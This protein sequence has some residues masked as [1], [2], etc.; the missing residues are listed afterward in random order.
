MRICALRLGGLILGE[1]TTGTAK[2]AAANWPDEED[3]QRICNKKIDYCRL[4]PTHRQI[5][6]DSA[7]FQCA[8]QAHRR[9]HDTNGEGLNTEYNKNRTIAGTYNAKRQFWC[10]ASG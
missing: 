4:N 8:Q 6:R 9:H 2:N 7:G 3:S 1:C 5:C 10:N